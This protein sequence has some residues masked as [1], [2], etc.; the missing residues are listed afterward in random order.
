MKVVFNFTNNGRFIGQVAKKK[1]VEKF[2]W[3]IFDVKRFIGGE[4]SIDFP[5]L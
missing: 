5:T 2:A 1:V 3:T 4:L